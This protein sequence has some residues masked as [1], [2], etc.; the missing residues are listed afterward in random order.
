[1]LN[2]TIIDL[3]KKGYSY[4][5][6]SKISGETKKVIYRIVKGVLFSE[7]GMLRRQKELTGI[8]KNIKPQQLKISPQKTRIIAHLMFDGTIFK[9]KYHRVMRYINSSREL[10]SQFIQD[11]LE[12]YGLKPSAFEV[13]EGKTDKVFK[14]T[15]YSKE[16]Y[17]DLL[18]Y[19]NS[20][21]TSKEE[22]SIPELI[23]KESRD[24]KLEFLRAF[25]EDEGSIS[26]VGRIMADLKSERVIKQIMKLHEEFSLSFKLISYKKDDQCFY[27]IY[28]SKSQ[29]NLEKFYDL[30]LFGKSVITHGINAKRRKVEVLKEH[31]C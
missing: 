25:W 23:F 14:V 18:R 28:L 10:I 20:Y 19:S 21:S 16:I 29:E 5:E 11:V 13:L 7:K 30:N 27:K 26:A 22:T 12:V 4:A 8:T 31:I 6:L 17:E 3:R 9:L 24:I 1:M 15:F 2:K